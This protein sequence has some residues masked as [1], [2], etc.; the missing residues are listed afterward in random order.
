[1]NS[2]FSNFN[3]SYSFNIINI[4]LYLYLLTINIPQ[5]I[6]DQFLHIDLITESE[7]L[8]GGFELLPLIISSL[9][10]INRYY[11]SL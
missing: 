11:C 10:I 2:S 6:I 3:I 1:M 7:W 4:S 8:L 5:L 9:Y